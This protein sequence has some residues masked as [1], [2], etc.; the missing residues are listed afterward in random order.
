[1]LHVGKLITIVPFYMPNKWIYSRACTQTVS[2]QSMCL[3]SL[4]TSICSLFMHLIWLC[5]RALYVHMS[6]RGGENGDKLTVRWAEREGGGQRVFADHRSLKL[7]SKGVCLPRITTTFHYTSPS[8][9][10]ALSASPRRHLNINAIEAEEYSEGTAK[11][12]I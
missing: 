1:M 10:N 5:L 9:L 6:Q 7:Q 4:V 11:H 2:L 12:L 3:C 8:K